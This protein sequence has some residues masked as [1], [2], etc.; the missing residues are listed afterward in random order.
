MPPSTL[1]TLLLRLGR[2]RRRNLLH[3]LHA[4]ALRGSGAGESHYFPC[5][6]DICK[7]AGDGKRFNMIQPC[8]KTSKNRNIT[9]VY[10]CFVWLTSKCKSVDV[11]F[12]FGFHKGPPSS[13][14]LHFCSA[15]VRLPRVVSVLLRPYQ[16]EMRLR[17]GVQMMYARDFI[18]YFNDESS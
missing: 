6:L 1:L 3:R 11:V 18:S 9:H 13:I 16:L 8:I 12:L 7:T 15:L 17:Y 5:S 4:S 2:K 14:R 10:P